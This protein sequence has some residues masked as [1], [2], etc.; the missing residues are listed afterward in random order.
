M[1]ENSRENFTQHPPA[2]YKAVLPSDKPK[3][4]KT[5]ALPRQSSVF[6]KRQVQNIKSHGDVY[7]TWDAVRWH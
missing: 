4:N 5:G 1:L 7:H 2:I 3:M 6:Q